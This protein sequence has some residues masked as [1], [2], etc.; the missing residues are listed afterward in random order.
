MSRTPTMTVRQA[1]QIAQNSETDELDPQILQI[2]ETFLRQ[3]WGRIQ[4]LPE[5]YIMDEL[6]FAV[7]NHSRARSEFQNETARKALLS[8]QSSPPLTTDPD[9]TLYDGYFYVTARNYT[10]QLQCS[11]TYDGVILAQTTDT[12]DLGSCIEE[13]VNYNRQNGAGACLAV[14]FNGAYATADTVCTQFSEVTS[15]GIASEEGGVENSALLILGPD[16]EIFATP[17]PEPS[18]SGEPTQP[19]TVDPVPTSTTANREHIICYFHHHDYIYRY[20]LRHV[21]RCGKCPMPTEHDPF[22]LDNGPGYIC[23]Q[24]SNY[25]RNFYQHQ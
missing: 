3:L 23:E 22:I 11:N 10:W 17:E 24:P 16:G 6:E 7:F 5:T 21:M 9:C 25:K 13:C 18:F 8:R 1:L 4:S 15:V 12:T 2:L 19:P 20:S 14:T